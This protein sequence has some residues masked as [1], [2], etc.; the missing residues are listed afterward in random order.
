MDTLGH[1]RG[2]RQEIIALLEDATEGWIHF[3]KPELSS[4]AREAIKSFEQG[5]FSVR[6]GHTIYEISD[7]A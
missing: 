6:V 7:G 5:S 1:F 3:G 4:Q 2:S